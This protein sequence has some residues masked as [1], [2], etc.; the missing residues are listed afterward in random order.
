MWKMVI[1]AFFG[2]ID[3]DETG[4]DIDRMTHNQIP[5][6]IS[7]TVAATGPARSSGAD[8]AAKGRNRDGR[9]VPRVRRVA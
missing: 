8:A 9:R 7:K 2:D 5:P 1:V 4:V 6:G 3:T